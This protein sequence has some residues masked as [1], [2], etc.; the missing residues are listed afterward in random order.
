MDCEDGFGPQAIRGRWPVA[1]CG[2]ALY[3]TGLAFN[4]HGLLRLS[5]SDSR[6]PQSGSVLEQRRHSVFRRLQLKVGAAG[7]EL[8]TSVEFFEGPKWSVSPIEAEWKL[9]RLPRLKTKRS[10]LKFLFR[11]SSFSSELFV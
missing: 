1:L 11:S 8:T 4:D 6:E 9:C 3:F 7:I 2:I 10:A 5:S